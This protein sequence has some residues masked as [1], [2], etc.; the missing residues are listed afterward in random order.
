M[1]GQGHTKRTSCRCCGSMDL[2]VVLSI[3]PTPIGDAYV[4]EDQLQQPQAMYPLDLYLCRSCGIT[5]LLDVIE[6]RLLYDNFIYKT[7]ISLGLTQH[8][9]D[10]AQDIV[11]RIQSTKGTLVV[12]IGSNDGVLLKSFGSY[13]L[14]VLGVDPAPEAV[15][16]A[17]RDGIETLL[18]YFDEKVTQEIIR[19]Y[20]QANIVTANNTFA[21]IDNIDAMVASIRNLLSPDGVFV[22]ETGYLVDLIQGRL[23]D[24]IYHEHLSYFSIKPLAR[25]FLRHQ[26]EMIHAQRIST[27][28][29]S[30]RCMAQKVGGPH[31]RSNSVGEMIAFEEE[32]GTADASTFKQIATEIQET[33]ESIHEKIRIIKEKGLLVAGYGASVGATTLIYLFGLGE[34]LDFVV[35]DNPA[36]HHRY[37]PGYHVP[38]FP[39]SELYRRNPQS[40][41]ILSWR[42]KES[43][44]M[45]HRQY[46]QQGGEF[47]VPLPNIEVHNE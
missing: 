27:K 38:V 29:G 37:T 42:Y 25:F 21:N 33:K 2:E 12:D 36:K 10:Y 18:S 28:G 34:L 11:A 47:I 24:V 39:S 3:G 35:D 45:K 13:G 17:R 23:I 31:R 40:V 30:I 43:I 6:P 16:D 46:L 7:S 14:R 41:I 19:H 5:V 15:A 22:M 9:A 4:T 32:V 8:F 26:M 44:I 20:G 1:L